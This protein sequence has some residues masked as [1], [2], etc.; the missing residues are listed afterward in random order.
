MGLLSINKLEKMVIKVFTTP[1]RTAFGPKKYEVMFNP[2]SYSLT[3]ENN[4]SKL[5][6]INTTGRPSQ[7]ALAPP[8][9]L[10]ITLIIDGTGVGKL[11]AQ[12]LA[13]ELFGA[14][15]D[16]YA[17]VQ[18]FLKQTTEVNGKIHE[19]NFLRL[20]WG[21]LTFDCRLK[22]VKVSYTLFNRKGN[23]LRAELQC[24]F[25][26]DLQKSKRQ[27]KDNFSSP[28]LTHRR[29]LRAGENLLLLTEEI[30]GSPHYYLKVAA[31][32]QLDNFRN[33]EPGLELFFPPVKDISE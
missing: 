2:S 12:K 28:D 1:E 19:P 31:V 4:F 13:D 26:G 5:Q 22:K 9:T 11:G 29:T 7:F 17:E 15:D 24:E 14:E 3:Y 21:D 20:E 8:D 6:G 30:Y 33:L 10:D 23:P 32:N 25:F 16:V 27:R 18:D